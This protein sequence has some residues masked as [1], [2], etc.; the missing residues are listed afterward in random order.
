MRSCGVRSGVVR[1]A[2]ETADGPEVR[3][4]GSVDGVKADEVDGGT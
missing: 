4:D 3:P 1:S 2:F